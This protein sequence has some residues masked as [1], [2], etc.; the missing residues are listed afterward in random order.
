MH[1]YSSAPAVLAPGRV[2]G[3][4]RIVRE[5]KRG[6]MGCVY[7][8]Q[9]LKLECRVALKT[10]LPFQDDEKA[11]RMFF[12]EARLCAQVDHPNVI[13][14]HDA[15]EE[16]SVA[17]I[18]M[19]YVEGKNLSEYLA[20]QDG[21]LL[22]ETVLRVMRLA[23]RGLAAV[24]RKG[25]VH[26]DVKPS[27]I[28]VSNEGRVLLMDFGLVREVDDASLPAPSGIV[29]TPQFM[30]PEQVDGK[31]LDARSD[32]F[33]VGAT[34]YYL[35]TAST[36]FG[37][38]SAQMILSR[39]LARQPP[40]PVHLANPAVPREVAELVARA[41][42]FDPDRRFQSADELHH[43]LR[44]IL[45]KHPQNQSSLPPPAEGSREFSTSSST[46]APE[47]APLELISD[48]LDG[49]PQRVGRTGLFVL[50][51]AACLAL[52][53]LL[54]AIMS[55]SRADPNPAPVLTNMVEI[56]A[57]NAKIG[58]SIE[59]IN[60]YFETLTGK[61]DALG[62][63]DNR[64]F[65]NR[66]LTVPVATFWIDKY[67]VTNEEYLRFVLEKPYP[68]PPDWPGG[69]PGAE[70]L[71]HPVTGVTRAD[72]AAYALWA[73]KQLP[74]T[75]QWMRAFH[76]DSD[77]LFPWGDDFRPERA[78]VSENGRLKI[79]GPIQE[80]P[81]D[82]SGFGVCN[83]AGNAS[84]LTRNFQQFND[85][86]CA[87]IKG[88]NGKDPGRVKALGAFQD[89]LPLKDRLSTVGFRCV[90]EPPVSPPR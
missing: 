78:N 33:S 10:I 22:W 18:I 32:I 76:G 56:K 41:M 62:S 21:P 49:D 45:L 34:L 60:A 13:V 64:L 23:V 63:I 40:L 3:G 26:R 53:C 52:L 57:G 75:T 1:Q 54:V 81:N 51:G 77:F 27:N 61:Y 46:M 28:M 65:E 17:F 66:E 14:I 73:R 11:R 6:G 55:S 74:T 31:V 68:P 85:V 20:D 15:G 47:L 30:S 67:E 71:H 58:T 12:R 70:L 89:F 42:E 25:L 43:E 82:I 19:R 59:R 86:E 36:P 48:S 37:K 29:G 79:L 38:G 39:I 69:H 9:H 24:H 80:T 4:C 84:E 88:G 2:I 72:A 90:Y 8:A 35:L 16:G 7:L 87:V 5:V 50:A 44:R 83:L